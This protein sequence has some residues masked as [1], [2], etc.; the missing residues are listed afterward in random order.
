MF[1]QLVRFCKVGWIENILVFTCSFERKKKRMN[2]I[3]GKS[4]ED[5]KIRR[6]REMKLNGK[7]VNKIKQIN[8]TL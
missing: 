8:K 5:E 1:V 3:V 4:I 6:K 2:G 7:K